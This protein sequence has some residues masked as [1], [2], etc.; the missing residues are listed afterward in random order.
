MFVAQFRYPAVQRY[1]HDISGEMGDHLDSITSTLSMFI[2]I[3]MLSEFMKFY[4]FLK[5][6][7]SFFYRCS[8]HSFRTKTWRYQLVELVDGCDIFLRCHSDDASVLLH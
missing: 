3:G 4:L 6:K 5:N 1:I 8:N 7:F 2:E